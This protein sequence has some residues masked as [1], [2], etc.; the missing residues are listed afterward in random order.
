M[1]M[2]PSAGSL[3]PNMPPILLLELLVMLKH[4]QPRRQNPCLVHDIEVVTLGLIRGGPV[5][6]HLPVGSASG[7]SVVVRSETKPNR[8]NAKATYLQ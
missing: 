4:N 2:Y 7:R 5:G 8:S 6:D 1:T 3:C